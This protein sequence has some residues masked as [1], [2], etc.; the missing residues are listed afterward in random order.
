VSPTRKAG[1]DP[2]PDGQVVILGTGSRKLNKVGIVHKAFLDAIRACTP[3]GATPTTHPIRDMTFRHGAAAG[4]D[5]IGDALAK[6]W[7][8]KVDPNPA[9]WEAPCSDLCEPGHRRFRP[10]GTSYCPAAGVF[11]NQLMIDKLPRPTICLAFPIGASVGTR[12]C[13][14]RAQRAGIPTWYY[15]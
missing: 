4:F 10:D 8:M 13:A 15:E 3:R 5:S 1:P 2:Y 14:D 11:R 7:G 12:D 9:D 6:R